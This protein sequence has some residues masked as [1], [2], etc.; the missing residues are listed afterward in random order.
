MPVALVVFED[1]TALKEAERLKDEFVAMAAHELKTPMAAVKG[2][3]DMLLRRSRGNEQTTLVSWQDEA[4]ETIDQATNRLVELTD[5][6]LDVARLQADRHA[7]PPR[8]PR[9]HCID[10]TRHQALSSDERQ[11][12]ISLVSSHEFV[13]VCLDIRR[14]E[15][16]IGNVLSNAIKYSPT[17][18]S[19]T[20]TVRQ[21]DQSG[22]AML[23]VADPG[24]GIPPDQQAHLFNRFVR[25]DNAREMGITGT[26][27]GLYLCR[28]LTERQGGHIWFIF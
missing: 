20:V 8:A 23:A 26:G 28:E 4:L 19:I 10:P 7:A 25:A 12:Y 5:D 1:V 21:D 3:A 11:A 16:I 17:G 27:L 6:L 18:G 13:V 15:Q 9:P 24:I 2:Y 14:T 22:M